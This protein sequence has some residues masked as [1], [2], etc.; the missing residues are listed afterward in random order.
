MQQVAPPPLT[1]SSEGFL[2]PARSDRFL[3]SLIKD[4]GVCPRR[5]ASFD[6]SMSKLKGGFSVIFA[7]YTPSNYVQ[8][9]VSCVALA[10]IHMESV[11]GQ[12]DSDYDDPG[13][14]LAP[15]NYLVTVK[16]FVQNWDQQEQ[17]MANILWIMFRCG[18]KSL[19]TLHQI[20]ISA[21]LGT[22]RRLI[23]SYQM[24]LKHWNG[25]SD[26]NEYLTV[27]RLEIFNKRRNKRPGRMSVSVIVISS[28]CGGYAVKRKLSMSV[29]RH[30]TVDTET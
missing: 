1:R 26:T 11:K 3:K 14:S 7:S 21:D 15:A 9:R 27:Q 17:L 6:G 25:T 24:E 16:G 5:T 30:L 2:C 18:I 29:L 10:L 28:R 4:N 22:T 20:S 13:I 23:V 19:A 8:G 12:G